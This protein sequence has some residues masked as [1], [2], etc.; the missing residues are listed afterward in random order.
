MHYSL[1]NKALSEY[2]FKESEIVNLSITP[3]IIISQ[4]PLAP[5][6]THFAA[7]LNRSPFSSIL[8]A[9]RISNISVIDACLTNIKS[10]KI[11]LCALLS[12]QKPL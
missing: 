4:I 1:S 9:D 6:Y 11:I 5:Y 3:Q 10:S 12:T 2:Y 7:F 8:K